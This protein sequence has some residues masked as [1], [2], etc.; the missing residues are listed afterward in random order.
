MIRL[1][2]TIVVERTLE[3]CYR[4]LLDF[5]TSEQWDPGVYRAEKLTA[6]APAVGAE[7]DLLL[8]SAGRHV[9]MRY[10]L[11]ETSGNCI[12][13]LGEGPGFSAD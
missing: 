2:E 1:H 13:L 8:N 7:F 3:D 10:T 11:K 12:R 4:Y 9:P 5:S 6:G